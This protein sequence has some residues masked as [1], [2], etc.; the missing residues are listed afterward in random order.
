M[1]DLL[2]KKDL[3]VRRGLYIKPDM[4]KRLD[5]LM[6]ETGIKS[7]NHIMCQL[8]ELGLAELDRI[9]EAGGAEALERKRAAGAV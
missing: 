6:E 1:T 2:K 9:K 5:A 4:D 8:M 7:R 3:G